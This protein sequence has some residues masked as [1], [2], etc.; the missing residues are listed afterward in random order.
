MRFKELIVRIYFGWRIVFFRTRRGRQGQWSL[1]G[2]HGDRFHL[3]A[4]QGIE[5]WQRG[6]EGVCREQSRLAEAEDQPRTIVARQ[7]N[8]WRQLFECQ[9]A[10]GNGTPGRVQRLLQGTGGPGFAGALESGLVAHPLLEIFCGGLGNSPGGLLENLLSLRPD[11][12]YPLQ[13]QGRGYRSHIPETGCP[14][15]IEHGWPHALTL[16]QFVEIQRGKVPFEGFCPI[17]RHLPRMAAHPRAH[18]SLGASQGAADRLFQ[19]LHPQ[20]PLVNR[21]A[22]Q[23]LPPPEI[24]KNHR[25]GQGHHRDNDHLQPIPHAS[26][27][28]GHQPGNASGLMV[29]TISESPPS[30]P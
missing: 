1:G 20:G 17:V 28:D 15:G 24:K 21:R 11:T 3:F 12:W 23:D 8:A 5:R 4:K 6:I 26:P 14:Q 2:R 10:S 7:S 19:A 30:R 22:G 27:P 16:L 25:Q 13:A 9:T 18:F 29:C